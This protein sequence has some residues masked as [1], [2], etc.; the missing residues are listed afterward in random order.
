[1]IKKSFSFYSHV[2]IGVLSTEIVGA[3][4]LESFFHQFADLYAFISKFWL[5][6]IYKL[7]YP[8]DSGNFHHVLRK[9]A[10]FS[11]SRSLII[12]FWLIIH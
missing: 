11:C 6:F 10:Y 8:E 9:N 5:F 4:K 12:N 1:M 3:S 2:E 7:F